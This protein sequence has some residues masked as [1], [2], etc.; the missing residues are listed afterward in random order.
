MQGGETQTEPKSRPEMG[1]SREFGE[2]KV[3]SRCRADNQQ[4][5]GHRS[6]QLVTGQHACEE[7]SKGKEKNRR[8]KEQEEI[9]TPQTGLGTVHILHQQSRDTLAY[10]ASGL[11]TETTVA[12][13]GWLNQPETKGCAGPTRKDQNMEKSVQS[14]FFLQSEERWIQYFYDLILE[15]RKKI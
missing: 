14:R 10:G 5:G 1:D 9:P 8:N 7:N 12:L 4:G 3:A 6:L 2:V 11:S 13:V 15:Q